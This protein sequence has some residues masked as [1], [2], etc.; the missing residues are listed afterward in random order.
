MLFSNFL[1]K[2]W[3]IDICNLDDLQG[4]DMNFK[5]PIPNGYILYDFIYITVLKWQNYGEQISG[6]QGS[7][8]G[9]GGEMAIQG[10]Y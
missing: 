3:I 9:V 6:G 2:D 1:K 10:Y 8:I 4:N 5:K 7:G